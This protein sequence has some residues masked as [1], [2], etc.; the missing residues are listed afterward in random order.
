MACES[1]KMVERSIDVQ[2]DPG[3]D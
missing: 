2:I 1:I 3:R